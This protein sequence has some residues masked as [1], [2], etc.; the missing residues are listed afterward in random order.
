MSND[1]KPDPKPEAKPAAKK[2]L[3]LSEEDIQ[4][5]RRSAFGAFG[6]VGAAAT[7]A[8]KVI[9]PSQRGPG[10]PSDPDA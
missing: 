6:R 8:G 9:D 5:D 1:P 10:A 2:P 3:T 4:I 7:G